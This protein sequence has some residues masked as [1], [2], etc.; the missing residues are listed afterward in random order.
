MATN[1]AAR[2]KRKLRIRKKI[3]GT[4]ERP[5]L[6][7]SRSTKHIYAQVI[8]DI[9]GKTLVSVHSFKDEKRAG[10]DQCKELGKRIGEACKKQNINQIVFDKNG[11]EYHGR[12]KA[13]AD[14]C[15]EAGIQF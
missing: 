12:I 2:L 5:R 4:L 9:A 6:T 15:R 11:Y 8:D 3:S 7:V 13:L 10:V 1:L 14:G